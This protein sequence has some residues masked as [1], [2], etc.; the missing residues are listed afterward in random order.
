MNGSIGIAKKK[1]VSIK[2]HRDHE[3]QN[4]DLL[5][6]LIVTEVSDLGEE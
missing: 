2:I 6:Y 5:L 1:D 4:W 3:N